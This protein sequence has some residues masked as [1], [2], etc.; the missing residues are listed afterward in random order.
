MAGDDYDVSWADALTLGTINSVVVEDCTIS[1]TNWY[2]G[3]NGAT[4]DTDRGGRRTIR[5]CTWSNA[6]NIS[7]SPIID[8][9]GNQ[10]EVADQV[11]TEPPG[12]TGVGPTAYNRGTR[13]FEC[14]NN[15][16]TTETFSGKSYRLTDLRGGTCLFWGNTYTGSG[17][18]T[19]F[20]VREEDG[21]GR[22][23][24]LSA[25]PGYDFHNLW[26]WDN[27]VNDAAITEVD[28]AYAEDGDFIVAD[29]NL[30]WEAKAG[31]NPL[32]YPHPFRDPLPPS[33]LTAT[34]AG[35]AVI[36]LSWTDN[37][38]NETGFK[39]ERGTDGIAF[40]LIATVGAGVTTYSDTGLNGGTTYYYRI[41]AYNDN[42]NSAYST[43]NATAINWPRLTFGSPTGKGSKKNT[44][45]VSV[46]KEAIRTQYG[47]GAIGLG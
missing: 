25:Y 9:H 35:S 19:K 18:A 7:F 37:S 36:D 17:M 24:W 41:Y 23:D 13:Q 12:G 8:V 1:Y 14:Y 29:T 42:G 30:F 16:F 15:T 39:V 34:A 10:V 45:R 40:S 44:V 28:F 22:F 20:R 43:A 27:T 4:F 32:T 5:Y 31:Y 11:A 3:V 26:F 46:Q 2:N 33:E 6:L 47:V 21:P 38:S